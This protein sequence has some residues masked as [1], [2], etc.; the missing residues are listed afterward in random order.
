MDLFALFVTYGAWS[1]LIVGFVL[2]ALEL[3]LPGGVFL[4]LGVAAIVSALV[5]FVFPLD[6]PREVGIFGLLGLASIIFWLR[7]VRDRGNGTDKPLLNRRAERLVGQEAMLDEPITD[8]FGRVPLGDS[9]WRVA[10]PDLPAGQRIR[11]VGHE[12]AVLKVEA[13]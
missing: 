5:T 4:W 3:L 10:G 2:L 6:W 13:A 8:G 1:W 9:V 11:I 7:V 12:G